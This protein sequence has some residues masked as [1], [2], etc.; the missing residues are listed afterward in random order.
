LGWAGLSAGDAGCSGH[1]FRRGGTG[2]TP[3][4]S[5]GI[6]FTDLLKRIRSRAHRGNDLPP[7]PLCGLRP[8]DA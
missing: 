6:S 1:G 4:H 5:L 3:V 8:A 2:P 7:D